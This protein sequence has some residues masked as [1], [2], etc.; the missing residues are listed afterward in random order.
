MT[1][2]VMGP[3]PTQKDHATVSHFCDIA[4]AMQK[5]FGRYNAAETIHLSVQFALAYTRPLHEML[6]PLMDG[7]SQGM[8]NGD[9]F[10]A[11]WVS[12]SLRLEV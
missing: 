10:Y 3:T 8:K 6:S 5:R 12:Q 1:N 2:S 11:M 9:I 4:F 7:Y